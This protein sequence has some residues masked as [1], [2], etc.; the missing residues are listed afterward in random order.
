MTI[1][2]G[3]GGVEHDPLS[4]PPT[5]SATGFNNDQIS[6]FKNIKF[7]LQ[8]KGKF[9][10]QE[11]NKPGEAIVQ[12]AK[13]WDAMLIVMGSRGLGTL[14]RTFLG[15]VSSFVVHHAPCGVLVHQTHQ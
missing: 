6:S 12:V 4:S 3:R 15:S 1:F 9:D 8:I 10:V 11:S 13:E 5:G 14:A 7:W 2:T